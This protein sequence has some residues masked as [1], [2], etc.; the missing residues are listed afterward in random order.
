MD[1]S[2]FGDATKGGI[3]GVM[4][5]PER[6]SGKH[7][8]SLFYY[9]VGFE[10]PDGIELQRQQPPA[11]AYAW[12]APGNDHFMGAFEHY[13]PVQARSATEPSTP[14]EF[15]QMFATS[16][17]LDP[18]SLGEGT[19]LL[20]LDR[21]ELRG[22]E[23]HL[24]PGGVSMWLMVFEYENPHLR[25]DG[26]RS[27]MG[28]IVMGGIPGSPFVGQSDAVRRFRESIRITSMFD[29]KVDL[30]VGPCPPDV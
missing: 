20:C 24:E 27:F 28:V 22:Y 11:T 19:P 25:P 14:L 23:W 3:I 5:L 8:L 2:I 7:S 6:V 18:R 29:P 26:Y 13:V 16:L 15:A 21:R 17:G 12:Q 30:R 10:L 1:G 4:E 9:E